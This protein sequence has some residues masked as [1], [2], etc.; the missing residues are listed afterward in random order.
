MVQ[1]QRLA[2][3]LGSAQELL[4]TEQKDKRDVIPQPGRECFPGL[5]LSAGAGKGEKLRL[6]DA[7]SP[8]HPRGELSPQAGLRLSAV[9]A[10]AKGT[11]NVTL[12]IISLCPG[13]RCSAPSLQ[14]AFINILSLPG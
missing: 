10:E 3:S 5:G 4:S 9:T 7:E 12:L 8:S 6:G 2:Q 1:Y 14:L 13:G 11:S